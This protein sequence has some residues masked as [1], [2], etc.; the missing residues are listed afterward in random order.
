M[1]SKVR[2]RD[3][4]T[5]YLD[6]STLCDAFRAHTL[7]SVKA[8]HPAYRP[9]L[10][11]I[12]RVAREANLCLSLFHLAELARW[13][14]VDTADAMARW[15]DGLPIVWVL[16]PVE[17]DN[18]E[19]EYWVKRAAG[20]I[21]AEPANAFAPSLLSTLSDLTQESL[22]AVL[23]NGATAESFVKAFRAKGHD[24][25][26]LLSAAQDFRED[27][28]WADA[29]GW[30]DERKAEEL[31]YKRRVELRTRAMEAD[32]RLTKRGD[33]EYDAKS[34]T[35]GGVQDL[36]VSLFASD[37]RA[38]PCYRVRTRFNQGFVA[39]ALRRPGPSK[40]E[41]GALSGSFHDFIHV[42]AGAAYCDVFTC[43]DV[44]SG[45][46][47]NLRADLGLAAQLSVKGL[48]GPEAFV[49]ALMAT[50]P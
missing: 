2:D 43:D 29:Q 49:K 7:G 44:V 6:H 46:L 1:P 39:A 17:L 36:L 21:P 4:P 20:V 26:A 10:G 41:A 45:W 48:G 37:P 12:E 25:E 31:G 14:E 16:S 27:R 11:W 13:G 23:A 32:R 15:Y 47:G 42:S 24:A 5:F 8:A 9:L 30:S 3:K 35:A 18:A 22:A 33:A 40:G 38:M 28:A 50:W 34:C 19:D